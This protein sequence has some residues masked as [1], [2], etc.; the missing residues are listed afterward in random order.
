MPH[1]HTYAK[2]SC[3]D[4]LHLPLVGGG[5][6]VGMWGEVSH[7]SYLQKLETKPRLLTFPTLLF[8]YQMPPPLVLTHGAAGT[9]AGQRDCRQ[10]TLPHPS[11]HHPSKG[12]RSYFLPLLTSQ[13]AS[14]SS[15]FL[16]ETSPPTFFPWRA[17]G[18][19]GFWGLGLSL[20][21]LCGAETSG[22][23]ECVS[24]VMS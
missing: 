4:S 14:D 2:L 1:C 15:E 5:V 22:G 16:A 11:R 9:A 8:K 10:P 17:A 19:P 6:W 20:L 12:Q 21:L 23:G 24:T 18:V 7:S 13:L 3:L